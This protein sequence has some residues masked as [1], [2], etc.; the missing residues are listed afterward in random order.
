MNNISSHV[1]GLDRQGLAVTNPV[2]TF[3][4]TTA[5]GMKAYAVAAG[6]LGGANGEAFRLL[7]VN[8]G[9]FPWTAAEVNPN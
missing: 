3:T 6:S 2:A 9:V 4:V 8:T 5:A 7:I 1:E